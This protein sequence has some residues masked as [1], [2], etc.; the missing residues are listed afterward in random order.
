MNENYRHK[1]WQQGWAECTACEG[2]LHRPGCTSRRKPEIDCCPA[3]HKALYDKG[4]TVGIHD[5][6]PMWVNTAMC[7]SCAGAANKTKMRRSVGT[8]CGCGRIDV[9]VWTQKA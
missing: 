2:R 5:A 8:C 4:V 3:R 1:C 6:I 7:I 9:E